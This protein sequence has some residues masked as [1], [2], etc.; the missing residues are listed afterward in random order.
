VTDQDELHKTISSLHEK[1][2]RALA[3]LEGLQSRSAGAL[4]SPRRAKIKSSPLT[5]E[6]VTALQAQFVRLYELWISGHEV[7]TQQELEELDADQ[8]RRLADANNLNVTSKTP[9]QKALYLIGARFREKS[10]SISRS[11]PDRNR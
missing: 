8:I 2:D 4:R 9:K 10:Y 1:V 5:Q 3:I 11:E 7:E 6:D